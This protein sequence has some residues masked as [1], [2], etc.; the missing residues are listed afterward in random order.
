MKIRLRSLLCSV[1]VNHAKGN[2]FLT[3]P[4]LWEGNQQSI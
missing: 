1:N 2:I 4:S 3:M